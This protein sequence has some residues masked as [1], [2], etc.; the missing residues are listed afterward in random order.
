MRQ[1]CELL[2][3]QPQI[4]PI[5]NWTRQ[6]KQS[7]SPC[8]HEC[9]NTRRKSLLLSLGSWKPPIC[10]YS[11]TWTSDSPF[12]LSLCAWSRWWQP[13]ICVP[14]QIIQHKQCK[15]FLKLHWN[16]QWGLAQCQMCYESVT[17]VSS[18]CSLVV[19]FHFI[20]TQAVKCKWMWT[21]CVSLLQWQTS[22]D[23]ANQ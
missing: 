13:P 17:K 21:L 1:H 11:H 8:S 19:A 16:K 2:F 22:E 12:G 5:W 23:M 20:I 6:L 3:R 4:C 7:L 15:V 10:P 14:R 9:Q 18:Q